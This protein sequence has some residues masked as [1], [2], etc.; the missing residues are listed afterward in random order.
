MV[1]CVG[2]DEGRGQ[3]G[4][5]SGLAGVDARSGGRGGG[6]AVEE[7]RPRRREGSDAAA[8]AGNDASGARSGEG[9]GASC[10]WGAETKFYKFS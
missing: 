10:S 2:A 3:S 1:R 4:R 8:A 5:W 6:A 9:I 7:R